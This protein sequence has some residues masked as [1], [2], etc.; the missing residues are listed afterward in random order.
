MD[1]LRSEEKGASGMTLEVEVKFFCSDF[2]ALRSGLRDSGAFF[3]HTR[4][5]QNLVFDTPD[6]RLRKENML[7]RL[8]STGS[9]GGVLCLKK[10]PADS[11]PEDVK[12]WE[13]L[14]TEVERS[15]ELRRLFLAL[16]YIVSF[17]YEK[18][19]EQWELDG[20]QVCLD[21]LPFGRF[22]EIEG[23]R[24]AIFDLAERLGLASCSRTVKNYHELNREYRARNHL[25]PDDSFVFSES[26]KSRLIE[27]YSGIC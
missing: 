11:Q 6:Y 16:G 24:Q 20:C 22:V 12:A 19:R 2:Q 3:L 18:V 26:D 13:E 25:P 17:S 21:I 27:S 14:E 5:E 10:P 15:D 4:F 1:M 9:Q 8:R 23:E 7:L